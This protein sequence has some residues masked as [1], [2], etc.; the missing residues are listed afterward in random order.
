MRIVFM[1][2]AEFACPA[3]HALLESRHALAGCVTQPDRPRGRHLKLAPCPVKALAEARGISVLSPERIAEASAL[4]LLEAWQPE[5]IVVAAYGQ[6]IPARL[7]ALPR[8][9]CINIH[10]SLLPRYRGAAPIQWAVANGETVTGVSILHVSPKMDAGDIILQEPYPVGEEDTA[11]SLEPKLAEFGA[12]LMMKAIDQ[13]EAGTA[14]RR[15]QDEGSVT[16]ARKLEK[17]DGR[18]DWRKSAAVLRNEIRG[19]Q[20]WPGSYTLVQNKRL[21]ILFA[22]VEAQGGEPGTVLEARGDGL[23]VACGQGALRLVEVQPEGRP[24]MPGRAY[25]NGLSGVCGQILPGKP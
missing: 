7:L 12:D 2:S 23:L 18:L 16:W 5:V 25:V 20:P 19:F 15:P 17:E 24:P 8:V 13:L 22:R 11:G 21:K 14:A 6:Y 3:V 4:E 9:A 1:G 10:P